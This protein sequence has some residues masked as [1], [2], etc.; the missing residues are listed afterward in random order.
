MEEKIRVRF[1]GISS[2][3]WEHPSD[4]AALSVLRRVPGLDELLK[5]F[6]GFTSDKSLR[7]LFLGTSLKTSPLQFPQAHRILA[8]CCS[9][10]DL[11]VPELYITNSPDMNAMAIG[12][13]KP[14]IVLHSSLVHQFSDDELMAVLGHEL[15]H[16]KAGHVLYRTILWILVHFSFQLF[17]MDELVRLPIIFALKDWERKSEYSCDR[18]GL[19]CVQDPQASYRALL[20]LA[21]GGKTEQTDLGEMFR[22]AEEYEA[23]GD[24]MDSLYKFLN[25]MGSSHPLLISRVREIKLWA[26][27]A[28]YGRIM[29][30]TYVRWGEEPD[31]VH[32]MKGAYE[33]WREDLGRS[34][35]P[36]AKLAQ[37]LLT[38]AE[39]AAKDVTDFVQNLFKGK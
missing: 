20:K 21:A 26:E 38:Q 14:F 34:R 19:L 23:G 16:I 33:Q 3:A 31:P 24:L 15:G 27:S 32:S 11:P 39:K 7:L 29:A 8:E 2:A 18:A 10:L 36:G 12:I 35:D 30:G 5:A 4:Q 17:P 37:D 9:I 22:Q 1:P 13:N 6:V 25:V 28:E